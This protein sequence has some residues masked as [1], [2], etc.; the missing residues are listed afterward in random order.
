MAMGPGKKGVALVNRF[1]SFVKQERRSEPESAWRG[2]KPPPGWNVIH[3]EGGYQAIYRAGVPIERLSGIESDMRFDG[4]LSDTGHFIYFD[5]EWEAARWA[6][7]KAAGF[8][9][10]HA[11]KVRR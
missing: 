4:M 9:R 5:Q 6:W 10:E 7:F 1:N 8:V 3:T 2:V 11:R